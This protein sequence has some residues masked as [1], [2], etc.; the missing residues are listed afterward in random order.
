VANFDRA[1]PPGREGKITLKLNPKACH[2]DVK[3]YTVVTVNDPQKPDIVLVLEG[4][5]KESTQGGDGNGT[6]F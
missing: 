6:A 5:A 2:G 4:R 1:I 3:K